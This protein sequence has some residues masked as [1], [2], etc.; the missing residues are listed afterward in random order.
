MN[1]QSEKTIMNQS[2]ANSGIF[3]LAILSISYTEWNDMGFSKRALYYM[4]Q[5]AMNDRP[6]SL[7]RHVKERLDGWG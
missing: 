7:N 4:K 5:N 1:D 6:F 3:I 2:D